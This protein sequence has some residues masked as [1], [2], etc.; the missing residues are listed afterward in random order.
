MP[1]FYVFNSFHFYKTSTKH[2]TSCWFLFTLET[3]VGAT[4]FTFQLYYKLNWQLAIQ[5]F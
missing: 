1:A 2:A 4:M 3:N 5:C